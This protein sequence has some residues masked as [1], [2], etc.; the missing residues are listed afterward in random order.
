MG[1]QVT[2]G[3]SAVSMTGV[4]G[5]RVAG[6][7]VREML[8]KAAAAQMG[9]ATTALRTENS[10]VIHV[11]TRKSF[12]YGELAAAAA[13][14]PATPSRWPIPLLRRRAR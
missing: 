9:V 5:I 4:Y 10:R 14:L 7:A 6:A 13:E 1:L 8:V 12:G 3:S 11:A 2:G